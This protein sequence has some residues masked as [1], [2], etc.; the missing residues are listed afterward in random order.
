[1][2]NMKL[3][4]A[5]VVA[6]VAQISAGVWWVSQ[7][8]ATITSLEATV[9]EMSSKMAIEENVNLRRDVDEHDNEIEEL[10]EETEM[11]WEMESSFQTMLQEQIKIKARISIIENQLEYV[12]RDHMKMMDGQ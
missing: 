6:M 3:P 11:L 1:M 10:W 7:Q 12:D 4:I 2:E 8:A 5:L 9:T